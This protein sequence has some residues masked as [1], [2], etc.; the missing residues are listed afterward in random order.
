[1]LSKDVYTSEKFSEETSNENLIINNQLYGVQNA[2]GGLGCD[3]KILKTEKS[4][5][6]GG[7]SSKM[8][9]LM[10]QCGKNSKTVGSMKNCG[11]KLG[12]KNSKILGPMQECSKELGGMSSNMLGSM[13]ERSKK[14]DVKNSKMVGLMQEC[15]NY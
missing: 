9:G 1:M 12:E 5:E 8:V 10:Q 14:F 7:R 15:S 4:K 13:Q 11:K 3:E 2:S 6:F